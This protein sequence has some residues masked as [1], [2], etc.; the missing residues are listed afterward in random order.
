MVWGR[1]SADLKTCA[2]HH[3][4]T[5]KGARTESTHSKNGDGCFVEI[6]W[7]LTF[8]GGTWGPEQFSPVCLLFPA[9][10]ERRLHSASASSQLRHNNSTAM[11]I[12]REE[13][14][15][16]LTIKT[17]HKLPPDIDAGLFDS[18]FHKPEFVAWIDT[19]RTWQLHLSG[20]PGC[21]K[22]SGDVLR[23]WRGDKPFLQRLTVTHQDHPVF[24]YRS[25]P[26]A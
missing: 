24:P 5:D 14:S 11:G 2:V 16:Q 12:D 13:R 8:T 6:I 22:V 4:F 7:V 17:H 23:V 9:Q 26:E 20:S 19:N 10:R 18:F 15:V 1:R 25:V 21:G 3:S